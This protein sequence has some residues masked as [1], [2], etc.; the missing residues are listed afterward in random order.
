MDSPPTGVDS[1]VCVYCYDDALRV[2]RNEVELCAHD[3]LGGG[4]SPLAVKAMHKC[5][6]K[7]RV[8]DR[9]N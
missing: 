4:F 5:A 7:A 3:S 2:K 8:H 6:K 9:T 1:S